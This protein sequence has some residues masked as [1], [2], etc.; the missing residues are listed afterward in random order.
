MSNRDIYDINEKLKQIEESGPLNQGRGPLFVGYLKGTDPASDI[1]KKLVGDSAKDTA[2]ARKMARVQKQRN[3]ELEENV[4]ALMQELINQKPA[5]QPQE[6]NIAEKWS[7]KYKRSIDCKNPQGFSQRA[8]CQGRKVSE[9]ELPHG[10]KIEIYEHNGQ[11][12][13]LIY[14]PGN[15][16]ASMRDDLKRYKA[17]T[18]DREGHY[19]KMPGELAEKFKAYFYREYGRKL[20]DQPMTTGINRFLP[21][22]DNIQEDIMVK[23]SPKDL[24]DFLATVADKRSQ[25]DK[26]LRDRD[27]KGGSDSLKPVE[28]IKFG[29]KGEKTAHILGNVDD[30]FVIRVDEQEIGSGFD[31]I[32]DAKSALKKIHEQMVEQAQSNSGGADY[33]EEQ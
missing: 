1:P 8:H 12:Q 23:G 10:A 3:Q 19:F 28:K 4:E 21:D 29:A 5:A 9:E 2:L 27:S 32:A 33:L 6:S 17:S 26:D 16:S 14:I 7:A 24:K 20:Q 31:T 30:G 18:A 15:L 11:Q 22:F 13:A 25:E